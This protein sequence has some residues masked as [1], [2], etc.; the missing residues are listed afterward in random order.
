M[1]AWVA[2]VLL[3]CGTSPDQESRASSSI[4]CFGSVFSKASLGRVAGANHLDPE[5]LFVE[6]R[7]PGYQEFAKPVEVIGADTVFR[8]GTRSIASLDIFL[9]NLYPDTL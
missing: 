6:V 9:T 5:S 7:K 3:A 2:A 8:P 4:S 1:A